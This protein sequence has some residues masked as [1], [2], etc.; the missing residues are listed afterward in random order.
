MA[1]DTTHFTASS[2][3]DLAALRAHLRSAFGAAAASRSGEQAIVMA[4]EL[5]AN[6]LG[7]GGSA[8]EV[9]ILVGDRQVTISVSDD[10]PFAPS[11]QQ[12]DPS[13]IGGNGMLIVDAWADQWGVLSHPHGGK[14]VWFTTA[15]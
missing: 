8:A 13:R 3:G 12:V 10:S 5:V 15:L 7:H 1:F 14:T 11:V 2:T 6:S 9:K 4:N